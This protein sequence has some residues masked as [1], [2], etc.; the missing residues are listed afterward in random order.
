VNTGGSYRLAGR[1]G[2]TTP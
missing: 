2:T 1:S